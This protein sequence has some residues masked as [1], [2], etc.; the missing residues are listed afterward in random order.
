ML[1]FNLL[2][3]LAVYALQRFQAYLPLNPQNLGA[4]SPDS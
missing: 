4:V 3:L 1:A 2:G